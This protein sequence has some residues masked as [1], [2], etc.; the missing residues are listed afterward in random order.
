MEQDKMETVISQ[1]EQNLEV[2]PNI[3][4]SK[5]PTK[6]ERHSKKIASLCNLLLPVVIPTQNGME[7]RE[8]ISNKSN[9]EQIEDWIMD[10]MKKHYRLF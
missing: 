1:Y 3:L 10:G 5:K 6:Q 8:I 7:I 2:I 4:P 9:R